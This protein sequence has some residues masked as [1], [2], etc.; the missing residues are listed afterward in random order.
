MP[1]VHTLS[2]SMVF[3]ALMSCAIPALAQRASPAGLEEEERSFGMS[4]DMPVA[5][6]VSD[7]KIESVLPIPAWRS[8]VELDEVRLNLHCTNESDTDMWVSRAELRKAIQFRVA[9]EGTSISVD[10]RWLDEMLGVDRLP[11]PVPP[12]ETFLLGRQSSLMWTVALRQTDGKPFG[13]G[14]H[15]VT[16]QLRNVRSAVRDASGEPWK[17][18]VP[19]DADRDYIAR[20]QLPATAAEA[21]LRYV[22]EAE[23]RAARD[24]FTAALDAYARA[25]AANPGDQSGIIGMAHMYAALGRY[26]EAIE[27]YEKAR[28]NGVRGQVLGLWLARAYAGTR[29][30]TNAIAALRL[31]GFTDAEI[32]TQMQEL[33]DWIA[34]DG[35]RF[36]RS[37][38]PGGR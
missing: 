6:I 38:P 32:P 5:V 25:A 14:D 21:G 11:V 34:A 20:V 18:R 36:D 8:F 33:R 15:R 31:A 37:P 22:V 2:C 10:T 3:V 35:A 28:S 12:N 4:I 30:D 13:P 29:D 1:L 9:R 17:G 24:E 7:R 19:P 26:R 23:A 16:I 27:L